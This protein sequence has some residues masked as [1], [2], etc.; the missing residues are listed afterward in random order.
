MKGRA[1][2]CRALVALAVVVVTSIVGSTSPASA[3]PPPD[4]LPTGGSV[5]QGSINITPL[6]SLDLLIQQTSAAGII[7]WNTFSVGADAS[8]TFQHSSANAVTLVRTITTAP[9]EIAGQISA[10]GRVVIVNPHGITVFGGAAITTNGLVASTMGISDSNFG[11]NV[12]GGDFEFGDVNTARHADIDVIAGSTIEGRQQLAL[13]GGEID[14]AGALHTSAVGAQVVLASARSVKLGTSSADISAAASEDG[15]IRLGTSV[16]SPGG[17][18]SLLVAESGT[19]AIDDGVSI[20]TSSSTASSSGPITLHAGSISMSGS[21][22]IHALGTAESVAGS[23]IS[24]T[25]T[26]GI[27]LTPDGEG[28]VPSIRTASTSVGAELGAPTGSGPIRFRS[29]ELATSGAADQFP[30]T[31]SISVAGLV[32]PVDGGADL[33]VESLVLECAAPSTGLVV[34]SVVTGV[35]E[36]DLAPVEFAVTTPS[37]TPTWQRRDV[38][39]MAFGSA[40]DAR[41]MFPLACEDALGDVVVEVVAPDGDGHWSLG[42]VIDPAADL[43]SGARPVNDVDPVTGWTGLIPGDRYAID[44]VGLTGAQLVAVDCGDD[45]ASFVAL[46]RVTAQCTIV[47]EPIPEPEPGPG[48]EP[49]PPIPTCSDLQSI[50][51]PADGGGTIEV[52]AMTA[53]GPV[54]VRFLGASVPGLPGVLSVSADRVAQPARGVR[55]STPTFRISSTGVTFGAVEVCLPFDAASFA[56]AGRPIDRFRVVHRPALG[57]EVD[58]T[59]AVDA[60]GS[61][62]GIADGFSD[63]TGMVLAGDRLAGPDRYATA[64]AVARSL[65]PARADVVY[66]ASGEDHADAVVA[67]VAAQR[68]GAPLLLVRRGAVPGVT[69]DALAALAPS[70]IVLVGGPRAI[71]DEVANELSS[72]ATVRRLAGSDRYGTAA[73]VMAEAFPEGSPKVLLASGVSFSDAL[74]AAAA[75]AEFEAAVLLAAPGTLPGPTI[76]ALTAL[77]VADIVII[78]GPSAIE[79]AVAEAAGMFGTVERL[80]GVN[81]YATAALVAD[82]YDDGVPVIAATGRTFP[83]A[84]GATTL[85]GRIGAPIVLVDNDR[86]PPATALVL[87]ELGPSDMVVV[88]GYAVVGAQAELGL[89]RTLP[90]QNVVAI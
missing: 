77:G 15:R 69:S 9:T 63:F 61:A 45:G 48:P 49:G 39:G 74:V 20:D 81:R 8:V 21:T 12:A 4:A 55:A 68:A 79:P 84:L 41:T 27:E 34:S 29:L 26:T 5:V 40:V 47:L 87:A 70:S 38:I 32:I 13:L 66:V 59:S 46:A 14:V 58:V 23:M 51:G 73:A 82:H 17:A 72:L 6:T 37:V 71:T 22:S 67:G 30:A 76:D 25:S 90:L 62:C 89:L 60:N 36:G 64:A 52:R 85:A 75:A 54:V 33:T 50:T 35:V 65:H 80:G 31:S 3:A 53:C 78:G 42:V 18:V 83:D 2:H 44:V 43:D 86:I 16:S 57:T 10:N 88:G 1:A 28:A 19:L 56:R 7:N 11:A 24:L